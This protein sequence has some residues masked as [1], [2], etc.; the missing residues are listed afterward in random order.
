MLFGPLCSLVEPPYF[1]V[2]LYLLGITPAELLASVFP[3]F[4]DQQKDSVSLKCLLFFSPVVR[5]GGLAEPQ[6]TVFY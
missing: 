1:S 3:P 2:V 5:F 4:L 6:D